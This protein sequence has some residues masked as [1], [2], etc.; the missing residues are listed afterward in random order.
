M[1]DRQ[2]ESLPGATNQRQ[3]FAADARAFSL[4]GLTTAEDS[5]A[6]AITPEATL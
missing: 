1:A 6:T 2:T 3:P 4:G 5:I